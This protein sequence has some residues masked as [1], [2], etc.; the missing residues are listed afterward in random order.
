MSTLPLTM[1]FASDVRTSGAGNGR[2]MSGLVATSAIGA[3]VREAENEQAAR[4]YNPFTFRE[5]T[6]DELWASLGNWDM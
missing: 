5:E 1:L 2:K 6:E 4:Y 3:V